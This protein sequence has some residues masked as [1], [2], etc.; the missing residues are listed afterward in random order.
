MQPKNLKAWAMASTLLTGIGFAAPA[1]AQEPLEEPAGPTRDEASDLRN[2]EDTITVTGTRIPS[3]NLVSVSPVTQVDAAE[4]SARGIIRIED[5]LNTLP[6]AFA[7]Q[8]ANYSN[9]ATGNANVDLRGIGPVRTLVLVDGKRLPY[10]SPQSVAADLNQVPA[11]LIERVEVLTG[12]ASAVYGSDAVAGVVNFVMIDDFEGLRLDTQY[13]FFQHHNSDEQAEELLDFNIGRNPSQFRQ[14]DSNV[15]DGA[16]FEVSGILGVNTPDGRGNATAF[17]TYRDVDPVYQ[18]NRDFSACAFGG[19]TEDYFVCSGSATNA[20]ANILNLGSLDLPFLFG[21]DPN[22]G[23]FVSDSA[24][25]RFNFNPFNF[26][27][28]PDERYLAGVRAHYEFNRHFDVYTDISFMDDQSRSQIAPSGIFGGGVAGQNGGI[29]CDNPFLSDE[30]AD[31]LC[32][33]NGLSTASTY[34]ADGNYTGGDIAEGLLILRRNVEGGPRQNVRRH[35]SYRGIIGTRG[36]FFDSPFDYDVYASY[37]NVHLADQYKNELS[38]SRVGNALYAVEDSSGNIVCAINADANPANDDPNCVPVNIF[39]GSI[40]PEAQGYIGVPMLLDGQTTQQ[41]VSGSIFGDLGAYGIVSPM[42]Q[43]PVGVAF[44]AEYR[45]DDLSLLPDIIYQTGDGFGQGGSTEPV[46]GTTDVWEVFGEVQIPL[47][48]GRPG[49]EVLNFEGA[50]RFSEYNT[51]VSTDTYKLALEYAPND[52]FRFRAAQQRAVRAPNVIELFSS[53]SLGLFDLPLEG[54]TGAES[55][56]PCSGATPRASAAACAN[57]GVTSAQ[58]GTIVDSP[59]GQFNALFGGNPNLDPEEADTFTFGV[60]ATPGFVPGL[61]LSI[62]YFNIEVEDLV[63]TIPPQ[64]A[65]ELCLENGDPAFCSLINRGDGGTLWANPSGFIVATNVNT[66]SL[67]TTGLDIVGSYAFDLEQFWQGAGEVNF[68]FVGT[69]LEELSY[70]S[71]PGGEKQECA[72]QFGGS[73]NTATAGPINPEWRHK[74]NATWVSPF[75]VDITG[76]WRYVSEVDGPGT[77]SGAGFD[78]QHYFDIS[79]NWY[80]KENVNVRFG[81]NNVL[82]N[83][84]PLSSAVGAG[85]GNGNTFPQVYDSLGRYIFMGASVD[86]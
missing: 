64:Q 18:A 83:D 32:T 26:F 19:T 79:A 62:D 44:G 57:T 38:I 15:M 51:G 31:I 67:K 24:A 45:R 85:A 6:Q 66:G 56:D 78:H 52:D 59:A 49:I 74:L 60:I 73:C 12:G 7:D 21:V 4:I 48:E 86:F 47:I 68:D 81:V 17:I 3:A 42:A 20:P 76:A 14:P 9:G 29:N 55:F 50:Y 63:A 11:M 16:A 61:T 25:N 65:L 72:G 27:Q 75:D 33:D 35:T 41:V 82:D 28:R 34:D 23:T 39:T 8:G 5:M 36:Q 40:S 54:S 1:W 10:G 69:W 30:Q 22:A 70:V 43:T 80:A 71:I 84:P 58:Y 37:S 2:T 77:P 53:Q 46:A 13:S